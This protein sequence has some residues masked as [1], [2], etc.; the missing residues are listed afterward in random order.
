VMTRSSAEGRQNKTLAG[1]LATGLRMDAA[2][3]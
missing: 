2:D 3:A 1:A